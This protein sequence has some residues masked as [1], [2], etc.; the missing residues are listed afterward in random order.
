MNRRKFLKIFGVGSAIIGTGVI[1]AIGMSISPEQDFTN[2]VHKLCKRIANDRIHPLDGTLL[3]SDL[4]EENSSLF[5]TSLKA[6]P[7][8]TRGVVKRCA[9]YVL[10]D[11]PSDEPTETMFRKLQK[12]RRNVPLRSRAE[13]KYGRV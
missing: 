3:L 9:K 7:A 11:E 12:A 5:I 13:P 8:D 10:V 4:K 2:R 6:S 1:T